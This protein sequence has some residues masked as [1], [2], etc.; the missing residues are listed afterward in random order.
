MA[1]LLE[2]SLE[3]S[4]SASPQGNTTPE[5]FP[6]TRSVRQ[7]GIESTWEWNLVVRRILDSCV[8]R[9]KGQNFGLE[10]PALGK[11]T[12]VVWADNL[13]FLGHSIDQVIHMAQDFT[14]RLV[15]LKM[16][17]KPS[18]LQ[19][20]TTARGSANGCPSMIVQQNN[21]LQVAIVEDMDVLGAMLNSKGMF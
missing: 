2:E 11:T 12:H 19:F 9:W 17:W 10:S 8:D 16:R 15:E 14:D 20:L 18:S 4:A 3:L 21:Q 7:G 5:S 1:A 13:Y 6:F